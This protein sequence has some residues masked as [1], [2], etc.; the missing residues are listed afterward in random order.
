MSC[1]NMLTCGMQ[2]L[3]QGSSF[4]EAVNSVYRR[5]IFQLTT[6]IP[7]VPRE[8]RRW[9]DHTRV[10]QFKEEKIWNH[11]VVLCLVVAGVLRRELDTYGFCTSFTLFDTRKFYYVVFMR[12]R[13][14]YVYFYSM[15]PNVSTD[16]NAFIKSVIWT[17]REDDGTER[18]QTLSRTVS[19]H[20]HRCLD[21]GTAS[22]SYTYTC[23]PSQMAGIPAV[24]FVAVVQKFQ[25]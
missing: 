23:V 19:V 7:T 11:Q 10:H 22:T 12:A 24:H 4:S 14:W 21:G 17:V 2:L 1:V 20:R 8:M 6:D 5:V 15:A 9:M 18:D 25:S 13:N 16:A 3:F